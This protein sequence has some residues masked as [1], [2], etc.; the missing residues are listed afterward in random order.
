MANTNIRIPVSSG[1]IEITKGTG[2]KITLTTKDKYV[3]EDIDIHVKP[4]SGSFANSALTGVTY[5]EETS[6]N[7]IIATTDEGAYLYLNAGWFNDTKISLGHLIPD[8]EAAELPASTSHIRYG[9]KAYDDDGNLIV[10]VMQDQTPQFDG[11]GLTV[12]PVVESLNAPRVDV[13]MNGLFAPSSTGLEGA[14]GQ[15]YGV[16]TNPISGDEGT[17]FLSIDATREVYPGSVKAKVTYSREAVLYDGAVNGYV[18]VANDTEAL[19]AINTQ[20]STTEAS[21]I[22]PDGSDSFPKLYIPIVQTIAGDGGRV[23]QDTANSTASATIT[24]T[25]VTSN[26]IFFYPSNTNESTYGITVLEDGNTAPTNSVRFNSFAG[27]SVSA[28]GTATIPYTRGAVTLAGNAKG[29]INK[30]SGTELLEEK[31]S[32]FTTEISGSGDVSETGTVYY[33]PVVTPA[34]KGGTVTKTSGSGSVSGTK[35]NV[36]ISS[37]A[38][39]SAIETYGFVTETPSGSENTGFVKV[40]TTGTI[41]DPET[42]SGTAT[43][44]TTR[45]A[46]TY[47]NTYKGLIS[48]G[49][50]DTFL[51]QN[52]D[53]G[54]VTHK[55]SG[56]VSST[57]NS[58]TTD[59]DSNYYVPIAEPTIEG[60]GLNMSQSINMVGTQSLTVGTK[61]SFNK[62]ASSTGDWTGTVSVTTYGITTT[63]PSSGRENYVR[64]L[65]GQN[66]TDKT[67]TISASISA[68]VGQIFMNK[69]AGVSRKYDNE[70]FREA[71]NSVTANGS[72]SVTAKASD[73]QAYYIPIVTVPGTLTP[74]NSITQPKYSSNSSATFN[75]AINSST[76]VP[77]FLTSAPS[78]CNYIIITPSTSYT[79]GSVTSSVLSVTI[80]EGLTSGGTLTGRSDTDPITAT[81]DGAT[82]KYIAVYGGGYAVEDL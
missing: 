44:Q 71:S 30:V 55:I 21:A 2:K 53:A 23:T 62:G 7:T 14:L 77:G 65:P 31:N 42:W 52:T 69:E 28:S 3:P 26:T 54:T 67:T 40:T 32:S 80:S 15:N 1:A 48:K 13:K 64:I 79:N 38:S 51:V 18:N 46:V 22:T 57:I 4:R 70:L 45:A 12:T 56:N 37:S 35:P 10:G 76:S 43:I 34:G 11:G 25:G 36:K 50:S 5:T 75:T 27:G 81:N 39:T 20:T 58:G 59:Y 17:D 8:I 29:V 73:G 33:V 78:E 49:T 60:G 74:T 41:D 66:G 6:G 63:A 72:K 61:V 68:H 16:T 47:N 9:Y 24:T 82:A 19:S